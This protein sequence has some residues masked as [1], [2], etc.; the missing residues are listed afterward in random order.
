MKPASE[1][2]IGRRIRCYKPGFRRGR[3]NLAGAGYDDDCMV[4]ITE[5]AA[6][7]VRELLEAEADPTLTALRVAVEGGGCSGFQ[8]ALGFDAGPE[9][10]DSVAELHGVH[11]VVDQYSLPYVKGA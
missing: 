11:I 1:A 2:G 6:A 5:R 10:G 3:L 7:R 9:E 4:T 8:Y